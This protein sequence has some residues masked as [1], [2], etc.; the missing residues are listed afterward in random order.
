MSDRS[1]VPWIVATGFVGLVGIVVVGISWIG[2][3][4]KD[5]VLLL[6]LAVLIAGLAWSV[7]WFDPQTSAA[8]TTETAST[9]VQR[10][11]VAPAVMASD[12]FLDDAPTVIVKPPVPEATP[13]P[14]GVSEAV[15]Q[16]AAA[17]FDLAALLV[18]EPPDRVQCANCGRYNALDALERGVIRCRMCG[19]SRRLAPVHPDTRV[20]MFIDDDHTRQVPMVTQPTTTP[21]AGPKGD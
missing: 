19:E 13:E 5:L 17:T 9:Q 2:V 12:A 7:G 6:P 1:E 3:G 16:A 18:D 4:S 15:R 8:H 10:S 11:S 20:R 21:A 14:E